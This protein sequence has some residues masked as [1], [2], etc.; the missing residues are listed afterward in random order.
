MQLPS[1]APDDVRVWLVEIDFS[2]PLDCAVLNEAEIARARRYLRPV[3]ATRFAAVRAALRRVL[4][5]EADEDAAS[6]IIETDANGR[7][8]LALNNAPDFNVSHSGAF[9]AIALSGKRAVGIDIEEARATLDWRGLTSV[10]FADADTR[11]IEALHEHAQRN[12]FFDCWTAKEAVLKAHGTGMGAGAIR[13]DAFS[14]LPRDGAQY[15][16]SKEAGAYEVAALNSP[17]NYA[18]ALSWSQSAS[19]LAKSRCVK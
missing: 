6:L 13:M 18:A 3:D 7:P 8:A 1:H 9:G 14:V 11:A 4:A 10:V 5:A 16:L 19:V 17:A 15:A 2:A 12:A